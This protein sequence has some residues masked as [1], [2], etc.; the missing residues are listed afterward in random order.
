M[1][2]KHT[3]ILIDDHPVVRAGYRKLLERQAE[4][5]ILGEAN[6]AKDGYELYKRTEPNIT[7]M[8]IS[9]PGS[10]GLEGVRRI[11]AYDRKAKILIFT[12]HQ[13]VNYALKAFEAGAAGYVTKSSPSSELIGCMGAVLRGGQA[14]SDDISRMI[15][16]ERVSG[17]SSPIDDLGPREVEVL[18]LLAAGNSTE[19]ASKL[20]QLSHKTVQNYH[21]TIRSKLNASNDAKLVWIS[22]AA[23]LLK[24]TETGDMN[25]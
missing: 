11:K 13:S 16:A 12:M 8:D 7:L 2:G 14:L 10:S 23:G 24:A 17:R 3:A 18:K 5:K 21:S 1:S 19:E 22:I 25:E 20:L 4:Y 6:T 15:A 9:M